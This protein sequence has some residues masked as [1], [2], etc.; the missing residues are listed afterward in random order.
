MCNPHQGRDLRVTA[1]AHQSSC[2]MRRR[3]ILLHRIAASL[4]FPLFGMCC[5][6]PA[7]A[8]VDDEIDRV[9]ISIAPMEPTSLAAGATIGPP[10]RPLEYPSPCDRRA[11]GHCGI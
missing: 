9:T 10:L 2:P 11:W 8:D 4:F 7:S 3:D 5:E 6:L 1:R